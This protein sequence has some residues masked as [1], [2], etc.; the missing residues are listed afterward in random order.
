MMVFGAWLISGCGVC[1]FGWFWVFGWIVGFR[2]CVGCSCTCA[3]LVPS[4]LNFEFA[5]YFF[6]VWGWYN[7][8]LLVDL[9]AGLGFGFRL[10]LW[11]C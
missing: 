3:F 7:I 11:V 2:G 6:L 8:R 4:W 10:L 9:D 1:G 5:G